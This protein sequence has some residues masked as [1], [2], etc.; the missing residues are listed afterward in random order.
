MDIKGLWVNQGSSFLMK[1]SFQYIFIFSFFLLIFV[2]GVGCSKKHSAPVAFYKL[3]EFTHIMDSTG[4]LLDKEV[5]RAINFADYSPGVNRLNSKALV[6]KRLSFYAIEFETETQA[7][8]E[9][10]RLNQ[11]YSR[12]WLF[13]KVD[14]EPILEDLVILK[15]KAQNPKRHTQRKPVGLE[16]DHK[17]E[18]KAE[19]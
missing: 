3:E 7:K 10:L 16:A 12:N 8:N 6:F 1:K 13:D 9:A 18:H 14:G 17:P 19:H 4:A 15:F 5:G 11:Y 2:F